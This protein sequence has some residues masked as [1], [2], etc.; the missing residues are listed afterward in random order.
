MV[1]YLKKVLKNRIIE[2][3]S[4]A[5]RSNKILR[6]RIRGFPVGKGRRISKKFKQLLKFYLL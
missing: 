1:I 3:K 6:H 2:A 4:A 5:G